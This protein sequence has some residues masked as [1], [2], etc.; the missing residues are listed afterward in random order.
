MDKSAGFYV[1][2]GFTERCFRTDQNFNS[3]YNFMQRWDDE[4]R[5]NGRWGKTENFYLKWILALC[6]L[7]NS[8]SAAVRM[9]CSLI[10]WI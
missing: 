6:T 3:N 9:L 8:S 1:I 5:E 7:W 2:R 4:I 10:S